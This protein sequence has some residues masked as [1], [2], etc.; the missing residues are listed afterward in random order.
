LATEELIG[1]PG[2]KGLP[3]IGYGALDTEKA[4]KMLSLLTIEAHKEE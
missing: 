4:V 3:R 1:S 2:G